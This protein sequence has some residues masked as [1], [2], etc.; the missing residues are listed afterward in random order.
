M[1]LSKYLKKE[2]ICVGVS[3]GEQKQVIEI[4]AALHQKCG[5]TFDYRVVM[6]AAIGQEREL[7]SAIGAGV[8]IA[9]VRSETVESPSVS[10]V[11][12]KHG[13]EYRS[14][15]DSLI[16]LAFLVALPPEVESDLSSRLSVLLMDEDLRERLTDAADEETFISFLKAA[17][18]GKQTE[19]QELPLIL[20]VIDGKNDDAR[21]AAAVLQQTA[22]KWG[23]LPR[24]EFDEKGKQEEYF[25]PE[26]IKE[27]QGILLMSGLRPDR[28]DGKPL[29]H[30]G[31]SDGIYRPEH[32]L[33]N[34]AKA[35]VF[36]KSIVKKGEGFWHKM[37]PFRRK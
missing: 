20:A 2:G 5:A 35:P 30:A 11:T 19:Q 6:N 37:W 28:F 33:K 32:L 22:G 10:A 26:E 7:T 16:R 13:V 15:D 4:L 23:Y 8:S 27:A 1:T 29:L 18:E 25:S 24:V 31:V 14:P 17:E 34:A 3:A 36:H 12:L 21:K 9:E